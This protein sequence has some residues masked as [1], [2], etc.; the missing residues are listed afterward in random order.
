MNRSRLLVIGT[1][2][3]GLGAVLSFVV[4]R[5][6]RASLPSVEPM[7]SVVVAARD[8]PVNA[9]LQEQDLKL[10][11]F[12]ARDL[13]ERVF[14]SKAGAVGRGTVL[15]IARG[16]FVLPSK[17]ASGTTFA[18]QIPAGMRA[19]DVATPVGLIVPGNRV[20]VL[21]TARSRTSPVLQNVV[22]AAA[23]A[24]HTVTLVASPEDAANVILASQQGQIQLV[25]RNPLDLE[26]QA[27]PPVSSP[28]ISQRT[29]KIVRVKQ[30]VTPSPERHDDEIQL[31]KGSQP[32]ENVKLTQ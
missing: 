12:P 3:L 4:Y 11:N 6:L 28:A 23:V 30:T 29:A 25:L 5:A 17:L 26:H 19:F 8:L 21:V 1:V 31:I 27:V 9:R 32:R 16:E 24:P 14:H 2:A 20:D 10:V 7:V 13:P 15:P 22:V 18:E